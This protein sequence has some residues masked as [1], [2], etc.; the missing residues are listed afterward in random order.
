MLVRT[1]IPDGAGGNFWSLVV[2]AYPNKARKASY[3][4]AARRDIFSRILTYV[5]YDDLILTGRHLF[6]SCAHFLSAQPNV[7]F[8]A[9]RM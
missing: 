1:Y 7:F 5:V 3:L 4:Q 6:A 8:S 9:I 2:R